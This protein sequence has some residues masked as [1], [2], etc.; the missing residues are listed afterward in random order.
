NWGLTLL[1]DGEYHEYIDEIKQADNYIER[2]LF[3]EGIPNL[4]DLCKLGIGE[5]VEEM[6]RSDLRIELE[7]AKDLLEAIAYAD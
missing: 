3:L 7:G 2:I 1:N 5:D 4:Q 6:L